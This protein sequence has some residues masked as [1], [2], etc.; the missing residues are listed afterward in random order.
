MGE[1]E[2]KQE[3]IDRFIKSLIFDFVRPTE[4]YAEELHNL[5]KIESM[6]LTEQNRLSIK[7]IKEYLDLNEKYSNAFGLYDLHF[8]S[9]GAAISRIPGNDLRFPKYEFLANGS[10]GNGIS[11]KTEEK[12]FIKKGFL[13]SKKITQEVDCL[14]LNQF[15]NKLKSTLTEIISP[16]KFLIE[17]VYFDSYDSYGFPDKSYE[18]GDQAPDNMPRS[19]VMI[20]NYGDLT[21]LKDRDNLIYNEKMEGWS[22]F[23]GLL[24]KETKYFID[25]LLK[26]YGIEVNVDDVAKSKDMILTRRKI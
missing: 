18:I 20:I 26:K 14:Y 6:F 23:N 16:L 19:I 12:E 17:K 22:A 3:L 4:P 8:S 1:N 7:A 15:T 5:Q 13:F 25:Y 21:Y 11:I 10:Y 9:R 24:Q 2:N